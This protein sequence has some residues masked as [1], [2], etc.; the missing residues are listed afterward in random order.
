MLHGS[1]L[2]AEEKT[3]GAARLFQVAVR[4]DH[5]QPAIRLVDEPIEV[6]AHRVSHLER[7][8]LPGLPSSDFDNTAPT[9]AGSPDGFRIIVRH[10]WRV[11]NRIGQEPEQLHLVGA[12]PRPLL[13]GQG[14][15]G[16]HGE[17]IAAG[18][19]ADAGHIHP[20]ERL[21]PIHLELLHD[22][23]PVLPIGG[24]HP[25]QPL[26]PPHVCQT[27][28]V[29]QAIGFGTHWQTRSLP[30][31]FRWQ[32]WESWHTWTKVVPCLTLVRP[33]KVFTLNKALIVRWVGKLIP[34]GFERILEAVCQQVGCQEP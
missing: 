17:P 6:D 8:R 5:G 27:A 18:A 3:Q 16:R 23:L 2:F 19:H 24:Q 14:F 7:C 11:R 30:T 15:P 13:V 21:S 33:D 9:F 26:R 32:T 34:S 22:G 4:D 25:L 20:G 31:P 10:S 1:K 28:H 12:N 29:C